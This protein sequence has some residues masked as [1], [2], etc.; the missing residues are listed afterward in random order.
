MKSLP[1]NIKI[2]KL[3]KK[4]LD[5]YMSDSSAPLEVRS[6]DLYAHL[7]NARLCFADQKAFNRFLRKQHNDGILRQIIPNCRVDTSIYHHYE[8]YFHR[9]INRS[10][11]KGGG[12]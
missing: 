4:D 2:L 8:W 9:D 11:E 10:A 3:I 1:E 5:T 12:Q 7:K 6:N